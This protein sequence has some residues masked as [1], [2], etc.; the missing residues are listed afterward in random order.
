MAETAKQ[1]VSQKPI[2][3]ERTHKRGSIFALLPAN[4]RFRVSGLNST[5][6]NSIFIVH[7]EAGRLGNHV[8]LFF[9]LFI[10]INLYI[11]IFFWWAVLKGGG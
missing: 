9:Y 8:F 3:R 1:D 2:W 4:Y 5:D 11:D 10:Y 7:C 6:S